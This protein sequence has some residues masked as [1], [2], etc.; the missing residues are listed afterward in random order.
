[1]CRPKNTVYIFYR[2]EGVSSGNCFEIDTE[3]K[4]EN[5]INKVKNSKCK[6]QL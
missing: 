2:K 4:G 1:M 6:D 3:T 5:Y